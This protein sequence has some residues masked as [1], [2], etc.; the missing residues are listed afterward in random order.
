M[1]LWR[2][3]PTIAVEDDCCPGVAPGQVC[4]M[5]HTKEGQR[6]C[7]VRGACASS[8]AALITLSG[9]LGLPAHASDAGVSQRAA[10]AIFLSASSTLSRLAPPESPPPRA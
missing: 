7:V 6:K 4:P 5:H 3:G 9:G 1:A 2:S 10:G 8:T